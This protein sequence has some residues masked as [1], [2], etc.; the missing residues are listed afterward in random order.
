MAAAPRRVFLDWSSP[1]LPRVARWLLAE[2]GRDLSNVIVAV[3]GSRAARGLVEHLAR[4]A[5]PELVPPRVLTQGELVDLLVRVELPVANRLARTLAW[6]QAL[7]AV[8]AHE[9]EHLVARH[10]E[11]ASEWLRLAE[12]VRTLHGELAPEGLSFSDVARG[13]RGAG[14]LSAATDAR[15]GARADGTRAPATR[16]LDASW[17][18][19][20]AHRWRSLA[21]AQE[22]WRARLARAGVC[23]PH[24]GRSRAIEAG[25]ID[26][27]PRVVLAGVADMNRLLRRVLEHL[28]DRATAL[29][30]APESES[31]G[32]D[33][34]GALVPAA[35][36]SR[37]LPIRDEQ[38]D[39][40]DRPGEQAELAYE[41]LRAWNGRFAPEEIVIGVADDEVV[42]ALERKLAQESVL[43]RPAAGRPFEGTRVERALTLGAELL[44]TRAFGAWAAFVRQPDVERVLWDALGDDASAPAAL[45][46]DYHGEH[47]PA[48]VPERFLEGERELRERAKRAA[49][50]GSERV[51]SAAVLASE[52]AAPPHATGEP[53]RREQLVALERA[54]RDVFGAL[55]ASEPRPIAAWTAPIRAFLARVFARP[56]HPR[57]S[58][59]DR[60][61]ARALEIAGGVLEELD[62]L[63]PLLAEEPVAAAQALELVVSAA[64]GAAIPARSAL[65]GETTIELLGWL[66]LALDDA[67]AVV[68]TGFDEGR[69]PRS[70]ANDPFLPDRLRAELGLAHGAERLA[71]DV[72]AAT[73][74]LHSR[75]ELAFVSGRRTRDGDPL[76]AS[77]LVYHVPDEDVARRV[78]AFYTAPPRRAA[79]AGRD[80]P[81]RPLPRGVE[82]RAFPSLGVRAFGD[83]LR[84]PYGFY[85]KHVARV[86]SV[87]DRARE[88]DPL[89][90]GALVHDVLQDMG[91]D[92]EARE[93]LD[94]SALAAFLCERLAARAAGRFGGAALPAVELQIARLEH[95]F[96]LFARVEVARRR[97][98][99]RVHAVEWEPKEPV[100][101]DV[102]G[103]PI[104]LAGRIDRVDR[105]V[106]EGVEQWAVLDYKTGDAP[107]TP[108][109]THR[110]RDEWRD[111]QL[112]LYTL[113]ARRLGAKALTELGYVAIGKDA[114]NCGV[115]L[116]DWTA[117]EL[118]A[119]FDA[120][121]EVVRKVRRGEFWDLGRGVD[122]GPIFQ[123]IAGVGLIAE[124][125]DGDDESGEEGDAR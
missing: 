88:L 91:R 7:R 115:L 93:L 53:P 103:E 45:L 75:E 50:E 39:V 65:P 114:A 52:R 4:A 16:E 29:V 116:A 82:G 33:A 90:Y 49:A 3:P 108:N 106:V 81:P 97:D 21:H 84:S 105:R 37:P 69:V 46:D 109:A 73:L 47:L 62:A 113:I 27:G 80:A 20:E 77:R 64:R 87:D 117:E 66:E 22:L 32:F 1:F 35:W 54:T 95:R 99:W 67:R 10:P 24:E 125:D 119:A 124:S 98:G 36:A 76:L 83:Y 25:A 111:L 104:V 61:L 30:A 38:W 96:E 13:P 110:A 19:G 55:D 120:A 43:A 100:T 12:V 72:H 2:H 122:D 101:L 70:T 92:A 9:L 14:A 123:A 121:R 26:R 102:D 11:S 57:R 60:V 79:P 41:R 23:D 78:R 42:P 74:L 15:P 68:V 89:A 5:G 44:K 34:L 28:G 71:R 6:A 112:P 48:R 17:S 56:L 118:D 94:E 51:A 107:K 85:L 31:A 8:P 58:D 40:G 63:P 86:E 59:D 18:E